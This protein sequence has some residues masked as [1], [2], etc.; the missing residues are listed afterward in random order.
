MV[1][2][3]SVR[4][5]PEMVTMTATMMLIAALLL[6]VEVNSNDAEFT[7]EVKRVAERQEKVRGLEFKEPIDVNVLTV[8]ELKTVLT[9]KLREELTPKEVERQRLVLGKLGLIPMRTDLHRLY[10]D[11]F[12]E[13]IA[14]LY[15]PDDKKLFLIRRDGSAFADQDDG[16]IAHKLTHA[17]Q[18]Q[19]FNIK[20]LT[21]RYEGED[22]CSAAVQA[23]IE[24]GA[25]VA[26]IEYIIADS[27]AGG[28]LLIRIERDGSNVLLID[29]LHGDC[30]DEIAGAIL[31][32]TWRKEMRPEKN[33]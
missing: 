2:S 33:D 9:K 16:I 8:A 27:G 29:G 17:L 3:C 12:G 14:G 6:G 18:D 5:A 24:G 23:V 7:A 4:R 28:M 15:D 25:T 11:L 32:K 31:H 30:H 22:D 19:H 21:E 13:Q 20:E 1:G 10:L 26:M